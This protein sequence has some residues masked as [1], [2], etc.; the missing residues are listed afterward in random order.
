[1]PPTQDRLWWR[2]TATALAWSIPALL[3]LPIV[4][5]VAAVT[6]AAGDGSLLEL[7]SKLRGKLLTA[8]GPLLV[9]LGV[10][11]IVFAAIAGVD[12]EGWLHAGAF[13]ALLLALGVLATRKAL[14]FLAAPPT[15]HR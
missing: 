1:M 2:F 3:L 6:M 8:L 5:V 12:A 4:L 15:R 11:T 7:G 13:A 14:R 10:G 9:L